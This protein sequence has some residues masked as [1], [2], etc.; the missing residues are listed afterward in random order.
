MGILKGIGRGLNWVI[1]VALVCLGLLILLGMLI[2]LAGGIFDSVA[3][4]D[5]G[6]MMIKVGTL[7]FVFCLF[8][9]AGELLSFW[10]A[11]EAKADSSSSQEGENC[12][13]PTSLE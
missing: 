2:A 5:A 9:G 3:M 4:T 6:K 10:P 8:S 7:S 11:D 13:K 12:T 1:A